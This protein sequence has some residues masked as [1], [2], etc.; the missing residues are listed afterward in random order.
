MNSFSFD[1]NL[2]RLR[3]QHHLTQQ[4]VADHVG[5][6]KASVSK[7]ENS[8]A[9]PDLQ[10]LV[11]LASLFDVSLDHLLGYCASLSRKQIDERY[12]RWCTQFTTL[13]FEEV[14]EDI[15][16][17][18]REYWHDWPFLL[19]ISLL[20]I[21]HLPAEQDK[22]EKAADFIQLLCSRI[23]HGS[24][25]RVLCEKARQNQAVCSLICHHPQETVDLL[26]PDIDLA[27]LTF[28]SSGL[29]IQAL[30]QTDQKEKAGALSL[31]NLF[32]SV[33]EI[34][35]QSLFFMSLQPDSEQTEQ[36]TGLARL[37]IDK[38][39]FRKADP[40]LTF[41]FLYSQMLHHLDREQTD[42]AREDFEQLA[43]LRPL[44]QKVMEG[45]PE[46]DGLFARFAW[47]REESFSTDHLPRDPGLVWKDVRMYLNIPELDLFH[48]L[49][50][51]QKAMAFLDERLADSL[52]G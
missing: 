16:N 34:I 45:Q 35:R 21:N 25:S 17:T 49:D 22:R 51:Y 52:Q 6:T 42:L 10:I 2:A 48:S 26:E 27:P 29:L 50:T 37:L 15:H 39:G 28:L 7:W 36:V 44:L 8:Q 1:A 4:Q 47:P 40:N 18:A 14:F 41:N 11:R 32:L 13:P 43:D 24:S 12:T 19:E 31:Q 5:V 23:R 3:R 9:L 46:E 38:T 30:L 20:L 33:Q